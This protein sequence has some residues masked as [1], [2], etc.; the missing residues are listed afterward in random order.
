MNDE[1]RRV[2]QIVRAAFAGV[3]LGD[4]IGLRQAD[5]IDGYVD[6]QTLEALRSQD[7]A[8]NWD[9]IPFEDLDRYYC[10]LSFFDAA[11]MQFHLPAYL[12]ADLA[13]ALLT[14]DIL[15][16]LIVFRYGVES[17]F[18][19]LS[20]SQ[21]NAVREFLLLRLND[22]KFDRPMIESALQNYWT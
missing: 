12:V 14:A 1:E 11:G 21:R 7:E 15:P 22:R 17:R 13:G 9:A 19:S 10:S 6:A 8:T 2:A 3:T 16:H 18:E 20:A 4:G 5:G